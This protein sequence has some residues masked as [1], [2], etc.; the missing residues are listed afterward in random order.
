MAHTTSGGASIEP[1]EAPILNTPPARPRSLAG[2]H[3]DT[4]FIPAGLAEPSA[5]PSRPRSTARVC[6]L[7]AMPCAMQISD[8]A[9]AK[10]A[11]PYLR[12][13]TSST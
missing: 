3:S 1:N 9:V 12:P 2:N 8:Q 10:I 4:A 7:V 5:K 11:K 6:Q 13:I